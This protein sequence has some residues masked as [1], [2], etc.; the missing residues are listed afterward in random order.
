MIS[1]FLIF[2][3]KLFHMKFARCASRALNVARKNCLLGG[4]AGVCG[5]ALAAVRDGSHWFAVVRGG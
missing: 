4:F 5:D 1:L 2:V 3:F